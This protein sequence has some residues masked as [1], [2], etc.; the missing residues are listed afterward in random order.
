MSVCAMLTIQRLLQFCF[1]IVSHCYL[2]VNVLGDNIVVT[3]QYLQFWVLQFLQ[4][5]SVCL[6]HAYHIMTL[7]AAL[8]AAERAYLPSWSN[9]PHVRV[10]I[11]ALSKRRG[12]DLRKCTGALLITFFFPQYHLKNRIRFRPIWFHARA[13]LHRAR[14]APLAPT[15]IKPC[16]LHGCV[17]P[18]Q[19]SPRVPSTPK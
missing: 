6:T 9:G 8:G 1:N 15:Y 10:D 17:G 2:L 14:I 4:Y 13:L 7:I 11:M 12:Q 18:L 3:L 16:L 19:P 5:N